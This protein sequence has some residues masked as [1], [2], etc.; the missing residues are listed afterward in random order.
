MT[1]RSAP[2]SLVNKRMIHDVRYKRVAALSFFSLLALLST[3]SF[4]QA[5]FVKNPSNRESFDKDGIK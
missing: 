1:D 4:L 5:G 3:S 2:A